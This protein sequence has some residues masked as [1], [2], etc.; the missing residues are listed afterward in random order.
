MLMN[1]NKVSQSP[2]NSSSKGLSLDSLSDINDIDLDSSKS[3]LKEA[4]DGLFSG[5]KLPD[6]NKNEKIDISIKLEP[7]KKVSFGDANK[8]VKTESK[9][10]NFKKFNDI[11]VN[12]NVAAPVK[13]KLS[14]KEIKGKIQIF[15]IVGRY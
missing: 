12:P 2:K 9:D 8:Q 5:I 3:S 10:G 6:D 14:P 1:P 11:P 13:Q 4:R 15:K 7:D